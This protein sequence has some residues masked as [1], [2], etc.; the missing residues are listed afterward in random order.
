LATRCCK[1]AMDVKREVIESAFSARI[2]VGYTYYNLSYN[3]FRM[4]LCRSQHPPTHYPPFKHCKSF[5]PSF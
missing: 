4:I 1:R 5:E 2:I 3:L